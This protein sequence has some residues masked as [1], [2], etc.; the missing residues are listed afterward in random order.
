MNGN[1]TLKVLISMLLGAGTAVAPAVH[2]QQMPDFEQWQCRFCPFPEKGVE[3]SVSPSVLHVSDDSARF[4]N[5]TGL[6]EDG[7]Y[8]NADADVLYR[9][10][11][12]YAVSVYTRDLGLDSRYLEI[13]AGRQGRWM[14]D[15]FWDE[16][17]VRY[18]DT[19]RTI[20]GGLGSDSLVLP[21]G[22][23][24]SNT[25]AGFTALDANLRDFGLGW[26]RKT[27][28]L[29]FEFVQSG[30]LRYEVDWARQTKEGRGLT[31]GN[32]LGPA[33]DLVKPLDYETNEVDAALVWSGDRWT[34]RTAYY[35]S[36]FKNNDASLTWENPFTGPELGRTALAPDNTYHQGIVSGVYQFATWST[37]LNASY[38]VGRMEQDDRLLAYTINPTLP[39]LALPRENFDGR[40]DT[41]HA[42]IRLTS[43]PTDRLRLSAEYRYDERD[44]KSGQYEWTP[45]QSDAFIGLPFVN[46][47]FSFE[48]RDLFLN[49]D[50]RFSRN[51][52]GAAGWYRK[53]RERDFQNVRR[54]EEDGYWGRIRFRPINELSLGLKAETASRDASRY[55]AIPSTGAG[56]EQNPL[57][58]KYY[59]AD[60]DRDLVQV[61]T[62][63]TPVERLNLGLRYE[64]ARDRYD[65]SVVGLV[66]A[67]YDQLSAE[68]SVRLFNTVMLTGYFSRENYDSETV[69]AASFA[70][71]N[72]APPNWEGSTRDRHDVK[73]LAL[74]WPGLMDG[75]LDLRADWTN[76]D[77]TGNIRIESPLGSQRNAFP[78]L[79]SELSSV[80]LVADWHLNPRWSLNAGWRWEEYKA[81]D[82]SKDG[83]GP[84]TI[85]NVLTF[86]AQTQDYDVNVF[87]VGFTYRFIREKSE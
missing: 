75:K 54:N 65:E 15:L 56:A 26:D 74:N 43:R 7:V 68:A 87:M 40:A 4:G 25:T 27:G 11:G 24:R 9:A 18:D 28:G 46:P 66:A 77:T 79:S 37:T 20:Y 52:Q 61:Q 47:A 36:F 1:R 10:D 58:R 38:G 16:I 41:T 82:W 14:V 19:G 67:D 22:W 63:F 59:L 30:N 50:Y 84:A 29:G 64:T 57:L 85:A 55:Q 51:L 72:L 42:N 69:G 17:P 44:N 70:T 71:P 86:G 21:A 80:Q 35:G 34:I 49:A 48:D 76:A 31:W 62:D 45:V 13:G 53:I 8:V 2:A 73:G 5:Y 60:R 78:E 33:Q 12:G 81:D 3:G 23:V 6:D 83:V 39:A 32:F